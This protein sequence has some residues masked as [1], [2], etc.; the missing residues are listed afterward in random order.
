M[1]VRQAEFCTVLPIIAEAWP[2]SQTKSV[3]YSVRLLSRPAGCLRIAKFDCWL[4]KMAVYPDSSRSVVRL[5][6]FGF[7]FE[8]QKE[9]RR[10]GLAL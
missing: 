10:A 2:L 7:D 9:S 1:Y 8:L 6:A 3:P 4:P 5:L